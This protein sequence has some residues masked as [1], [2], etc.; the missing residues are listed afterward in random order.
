MEIIERGKIKKI[1]IEIITSWGCEEKAQGYL[2]E[3]SIIKIHF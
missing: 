3:L 1:Y 2:K